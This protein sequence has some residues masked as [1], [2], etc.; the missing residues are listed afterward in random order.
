MAQV[1]R[2]HRYFD[3]LEYVVPAGESSRRVPGPINGQ[4]TD[5]YFERSDKTEQTAPEIREH[6]A[7]LLLSGPHRTGTL[8]TILLL[9]S[10]PPDAIVKGHPTVPFRNTSPT[11]LDFEF[12]GGLKGRK[13]PKI[14]FWLCIQIHS[15]SPC[16][17]VHVAKS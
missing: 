10:N 11:A 14:R 3:D 7:G 15:G 17:S 8:T 16:E 4:A 2:S 13:L 9:V 1:Y 12:S 6:P 5:S